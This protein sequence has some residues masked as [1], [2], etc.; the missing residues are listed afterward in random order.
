MVWFEQKIDLAYL[1]K[2]SIF[3]SFLKGDVP[4]ADKQY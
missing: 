4:V 3:L 1:N 2:C